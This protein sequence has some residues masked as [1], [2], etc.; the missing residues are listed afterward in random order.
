MALA[1]QLGEAFPLAVVPTLHIA[2]PCPID[3][4]QSVAHTLTTQ[5]VGRALEYPVLYGDHKAS[6]LPDGYETLHYLV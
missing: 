4:E 6:S 5:R 1:P 2:A 3:F